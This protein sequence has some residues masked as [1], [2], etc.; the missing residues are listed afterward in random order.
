[1]RSPA[2]R[3]SLALA[4]LL[5][6]GAGPGGAS[7]SG[8][9]GRQI[10]EKAGEVTGLGI[11]TGVATVKMILKDKGGETRERVFSVKSKETGGL[12]KLILKFTSPP[13]VMG[14]GL[15]LI[16]K[17]KGQDDQYLFLPE[18]GKARKIAGKQSHAAFL[19]SDFLY[20]D[21]RHHDVGDAEHARLADETVSGVA[22]R[23]VE[24][25]PHA[26]AG[27]PYGR[28]VTW[29]SSSNDVPVKMEFYS[30]KGKKIKKLFNAKIEKKDGRWIIMQSKMTDLGSGHST[31]LVVQSV[32]AKED[33]PDD[34]FTKAA[35]I[36]L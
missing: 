14:A 31:Q 23:V 1:M 18:T 7:S 25:V 2:M 24:T 36:R 28:I 34:E 21:L 27:A 8:L 13:D 33:I 29:V 10:M 5:G 12:R 32:E 3:A 6:L 17:S 35:L 20:W 16:E 4:A 11:K 9:D 19:S 22:C 26:D 30:S 15:L